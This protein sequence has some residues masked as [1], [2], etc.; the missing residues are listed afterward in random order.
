ME[1]TMPVIPSFWYR[2]RRSAVGRRAE[3]V[4]NVME[5]NDV[6]GCDTVICIADQLEASDQL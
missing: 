1:H 5:P 3:N 2:S 4:S 6:S